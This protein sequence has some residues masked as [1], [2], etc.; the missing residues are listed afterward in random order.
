M[1]QAGSVFVIPDPVPALDPHLW[2]IVSDPSQN[3]HRV[4]MVNFTKW[5]EGKDQSCIVEP[6]EY[7][8]LTC[9]SVVQYAGAKE[10]SAEN[11]NTLLA[12]TAFEMRPPVSEELLQRMRAGAGVSEF[13]AHAYR[14]LLADQGL[15][16]E[17]E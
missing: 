5:R 15:L 9:K 3:H 16:P 10:C 1:I 7:D 14:R 13:L 17:G 6:R 4:L 8:P 12:R 11:L 2:V